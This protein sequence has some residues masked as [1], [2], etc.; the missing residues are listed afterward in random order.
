MSSLTNKLFFIFQNEV[1][2]LWWGQRP[3]NRKELLSIYS[4]TKSISSVCWKGKLMTR[5]QDGFPLDQPSTAN[6]KQVGPDPWTQPQCKECEEGTA[7]G[8]ALKLLDTAMALVMFSANLSVNAT[9]KLDWSYSRWVVISTKGDYIPQ[10]QCRDCSHHLALPAAGRSPSIGCPLLHFST[11]GWKSFLSLIDK[12]CGPSTVAVRF[13]ARAGTYG[14]DSPLPGTWDQIHSWCQQGTAIMS[15]WSHM[16]SQ[17]DH[18]F[19]Y[20]D[21]NQEPEQQDTGQCNLSFDGPTINA[22]MQRKTLICRAGLILTAL[23]GSIF[24]RS[25]AMVMQFRKM[26]TKTTWSNILWVMILLHIRR[27]LLRKNNT[28]ILAVNSW[29][30]WDE[31]TPVKASILYMA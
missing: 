30:A 13:K 17:C 31:D 23:W 16:G 24:G 1:Q 18:L 19:P 22:I 10:D 9:L 14:L 5:R 26:I 6:H 12:A 28:D 27:N 25:I 7:H 20:A 29:L 15:A 3:E 8:G 21:R 11:W 4:I 2:R